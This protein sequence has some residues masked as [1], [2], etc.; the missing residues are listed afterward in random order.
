MLISGSSCAPSGVMS[1]I[2][3]VSVPK[4]APCVR[5]LLATI[6]SRFFFRSFALE[7]SSRFSVSME[8]PHRSCP[9]FLADMLPKISSVRSNSRTLAASV[10]LIFSAAS[11]AGR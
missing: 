11:C 4:P 7:F 2:T 8:K 1:V 3:F 9:F 6:I 5:R 10:F